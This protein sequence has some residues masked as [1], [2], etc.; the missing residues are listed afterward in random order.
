ME[1]QAQLKWTDGLQFVGRAGD[2][3][4]V[5]I[6]SRDGGSGPSPM[7]LVLM[8]V[9]G[10]TAMDVVVVL[11]KRRAALTD[12]EINISGA[13]AETHPKRFT[14]IHVEY[15]VHGQGIKPKDVEMAIRLSE[16]KYCSAIA[17]LNA[18]VTHSYRIVEPA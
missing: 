18:E 12:L 14:A 15:V 4:G 17:S 16:E 11:E 7:Q 5:V 1:M 10:C 3:P 8:G 6:D 2:G 9:A 13:R